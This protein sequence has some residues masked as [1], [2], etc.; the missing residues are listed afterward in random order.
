MKD[1]EQAGSSIAKESPDDNPPSLLYKKLGKIGGGYPKWRLIS[2]ANIS[3]VQL[4]T[5]SF[6]RMSCPLCTFLPALS[7]ARIWLEGRV[8]LDLRFEISVLLL[9]RWRAG[10]TTMFLLPIPTFEQI[11]SLWL[12]NHIMETDKVAFIRC[13][14]CRNWGC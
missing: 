1:G 4:H 14:L 2:D 6:A 3:F 13:D 10:T 11:L 5:P 12:V 7:S 8:F 9:M